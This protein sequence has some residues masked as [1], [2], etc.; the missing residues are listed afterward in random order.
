MGRSS[1][2]T[3]NKNVIKMLKINNVWNKV[4]V[5]FIE[6]MKEKGMKRNMFVF[7]INIVKIEIKDIERG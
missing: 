2:T 5:R 4:I 3:G 1:K 6:N 7:V